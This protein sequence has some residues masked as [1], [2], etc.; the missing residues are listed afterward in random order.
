MSSLYSAGVFTITQVLEYSTGSAP[1]LPLSSA[2]T[3]VLTKTMQCVLNGDYAPIAVNVNVV[4]TPVANTNVELRNLAVVNTTTLTKFTFTVQYYYLTSISGG[5]QNYYQN[6]KTIFTNSQT[7]GLFLNTLR[8]LSREASVTPLTTAKTPSTAVY[9]TTSLSSFAPTPTPT[10]KPTASVG[11]ST[12]TVSDFFSSGNGVNLGLLVAAIV[13]CP[14]LVILGYVILRQ[15]QG[16]G[17][18]FDKNLTDFML[19]EVPNLNVVSTNKV[20]T[21]DSENQFEFVIHRGQPKSNKSGRGG[22]LSN[23]RRPLLGADQRQP[24]KRIDLD[25]YHDLENLYNRRPPPGYGYN[26]QASNPMYGSAEHA[27]GSNG[28]NSAVMRPYPPLDPYRGDPYG[29]PPADPYG[30]PPMDPYGRPPVD[31]YSRPPADPYGRGAT[32]PRSDYS[33]S[34]YR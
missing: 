15:R 11:S 14:I 33:S 25:K 5:L 3:T 23:P 13:M 7:T 32:S 4:A 19:S 24:P 6:L 28:L 22:P 29:R 1:L 30:R 16:Q 10:L 26:I 21:L 27:Y 18:Y 2:S 31:P 17:R 12:S 9:S 8:T 34:N 20:G